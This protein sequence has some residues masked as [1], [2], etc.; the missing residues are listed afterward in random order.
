[1]I[2]STRE[3]TPKQRTVISN[4]QQ[5]VWKL[6]QVKALLMSTFD[7]TEEEVDQV[8]AGSLSDMIATIE[9]GMDSIYTEA[10]DE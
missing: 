1:M 10:N 3:L 2:I 4:L 9:A 7:K 6:E 8:F 5:S